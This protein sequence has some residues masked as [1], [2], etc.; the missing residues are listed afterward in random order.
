M[1]ILSALYIVAK[2]K[3]IV[4]AQYFY[5]F[6]I[7]RC[8][9][10]CQAGFSIFNILV[11]QIRRF[12]FFSQQQFPF[13]IILPLQARY[14]PLAVPLL[15][16]CFLIAVPLQA[17]YFPLIILPLQARCFPIAVLLWPRCLPIIVTNGSILTAK[18]AGSERGLGAK[19]C[20]QSRARADVPGQLG[21]PAGGLSFRA[22]HDLF[23]R[24]FA[25]PS[26]T[27]FPFLFSLMAMYLHTCVF[28]A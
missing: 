28:P 9:W 13:R 23:S 3:E 14:S 20:K 18:Q 16:R 26:P 5:V 4:K 8:F 19:T 17:Q 21:T 1:N 12:V 2:R 7:Q 10:L 11:I 6:T 25:G 24:I 22:P 27:S 15:A